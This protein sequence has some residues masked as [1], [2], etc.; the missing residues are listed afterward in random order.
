METDRGICV[1]VESD[2]NIS[3][4]PEWRMEIRA[5]IRVIFGRRA[6]QIRGKTGRPVSEH[7]YLFER[8]RDLFMFIPR[9]DSAGAFSLA[10][11]NSA[12]F[13]GLEGKNKSENPPRGS[14]ERQGD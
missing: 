11:I 14:A 2:Q 10:K 4:G 3:A 7:G 13:P 12:A 5:E 1:T 9:V 8:R 6:P